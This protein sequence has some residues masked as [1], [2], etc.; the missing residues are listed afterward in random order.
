VV[1]V[2]YTVPQWSKAC[3]EQPPLGAGGHGC[4]VK[5]TSLLGR[6]GLFCPPFRSP[7]FDCPPFGFPTFPFPPL[8]IPC[9]PFPP[10]PITNFSFHAFLFPPFSCAPVCSQSFGSLRLLM[11]WLEREAADRALCRGDCWVGRRRRCQWQIGLLPDM[12]IGQGCQ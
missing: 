6:L 7:P 8:P 10:C 11:H 3:L 2:S 12:R 4:G 9:F 5:A 1:I